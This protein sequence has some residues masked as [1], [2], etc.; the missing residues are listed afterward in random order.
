MLQE[1]RTEFVFSDHF[2]QLYLEDLYDGDLR[3][4]E[5]IFL[6]SIRTISSELSVASVLFD[7]GNVEG[8][9]KVYHKIKPLFGYVGLLSVQE[10]VQQFEEECTQT[11][12][13]SD[14]LFSFN[15]INEVVLDAVYLIRE[16]QIKLRTFNNKRA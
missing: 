8:V 12:G 2:H 5:E 7:Q 14:L 6:S 11:A 15:Q 1:P 13:T 9:R 3:A 4:A 10:F 16:E